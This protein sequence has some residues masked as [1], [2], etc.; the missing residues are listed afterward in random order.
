MKFN[1][2]K[3][4]VSVAISALI[5]YAYYAFSDSRNG[6]LVSIGSFIENS[7]MLITALGI[8]IKGVRT[9]VN[10]KIV[11]W[12]FFL[13]SIISNSI[14]AAITFNQPSYIIVNGLILLIF[15]LVAYSIGKA[16]KE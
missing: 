9:M 5:A 12:L 15:V 4:A 10:L 13:V 2:V 14:F 7:I 1:V 3:T 6:G 8:T 11:G 16:S